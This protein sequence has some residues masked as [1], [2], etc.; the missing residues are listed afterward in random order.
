MH[1]R[2]KPIVRLLA[3][4]QP[5][6]RAALKQQNAALRQENA[7]LK[8]GIQQQEQ[9]ILHLAGQVTGQIYDPVAEQQQAH[10]QRLEAENRQAQRDLE[11]AERREKIKQEIIKET[12]GLQ[13]YGENIIKEAKA[14][15][16][17]LL[18]K[19]EQFY[20]LDDKQ[21]SNYTRISHKSEASAVYNLL[22]EYT[23]GGGI[24]GGKPAY[25]VYECN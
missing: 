24:A 23:E 16:Q 4:A 11:A 22:D 10:R 6:I 18:E 8:N 3:H 5:K 25:W 15:Q 21:L 7:M 9:H 14:R 20:L 13:K 2:K 19:T 12:P 17:M 1:L